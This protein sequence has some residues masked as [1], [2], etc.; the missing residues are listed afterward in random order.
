M[1]Y[2]PQINLLYYKNLLDIC[3]CRFFELYNSSFININGS[4]VLAENITKS[5]LSTIFKALLKDELYKCITT[6]DNISP[7]YYFIIGACLPKDNILFKYRNNKNFPKKLEKIALA[8][9]QI[10]Y[11]LKEHDIK[12]DMILFNQI[13]INIFDE[14]FSNEKKLLRFLGTE[15]KNVIFIK[16]KNLDCYSLFKAIKWI[17][18]KSNCK[19]LYIEKYKDQHSPLVAINDLIDKYVHNKIIVNKSTEFKQYLTEL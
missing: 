2:S 13:A 5:K 19:N 12:L 16:H 7:K 11:I 17:Y 14:L 10:K 4:Y 1:I 8:E 9:Y 18:G 15:Y 6:M 3:F